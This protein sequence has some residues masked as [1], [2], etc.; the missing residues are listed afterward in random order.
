MKIKEDVKKMLNEFKTFLMKG[1]ILSLSTGIIIG[2]SFGKIV[3]SL[4]ADVLM[5]IIGLVM[6]KV[7]FTS[8]YLPLDFHIYD[9]LEA[10]KKAG[11][12]LL[13]YGNFIQTLV[14]FTIVGFSIF[15]VLKAVSKAQSVALKKAEEKPA[16]PTTKECPECCSD[17][18]IK[19]KTCPYCQTKQV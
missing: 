17:I 4:V 15:M 5:P 9:S 19:A 16:D 8:L 13:M 10:A 2:G 6:G 1:D 12:P 11:A 18:K 14:D 3:S 7:S